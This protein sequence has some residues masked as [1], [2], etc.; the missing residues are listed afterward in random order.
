MKKQKLSERCRALGLQGD[1]TRPLLGVF[2]FSSLGNILM[3]SVP[4]Y[5]L[6][7]YDRVLIS[8]SIETLLVLTALVVF[9][10]SI[11]AIMETVRSRILAKLAARADDDI[12]TTITRLSLYGPHGS[13]ANA[14]T[15]IR[16]CEML[17]RA[18]SPATLG[19][20]FD[21][22]WAPSFIGIVFVMHPYLGYVALI[23]L[24]LLV[25]LAT[26]SE[27]VGQ[28][29]GEDGGPHT[30][31]GKGLIASASQFPSVVRAMG[32][33]PN[34]ITKSRQLSMRG[35]LLSM[36]KDNR[37]DIIINLSRFIRMLAQ[38]GILGIGA[39]LVIG[40]EVT[41]GVMIAASMIMGRGLSPA[42]KLMGSLS[43]MRLGAGAFAR[44]GDFL[45]QLP[46][47]NSQTILAPPIP[48]QLSL[49][50]IHHSYPGTPTPVLSGI[51]LTLS[52]GQ[53]I[54]IVGP[55]SAGKSTL[56]RILVGALAPSRGT[57]EWGGKDMAMIDPMQKKNRIG[58]LPQTIEILDATV[59][60]NISGLSDDSFDDVVTAAKL[61]S[62]HDAILKMPEGYDTMLG[63]KGIPLSGGRAQSIG[64]ARA[65]FRMPE[66]VVMDEPN[67]FLDG[68]AEAGLQ[69]LVT[70]LGKA[71]SAIVIISHKPTLM[72]ILDTLYVLQDGKFRLSGRPEDVHAKILKR[73]G[74][75]IPAQPM[76]NWINGV[77]K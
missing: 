22:I 66:L 35:L 14:P 75:K 36:S 55:N 30:I 17:R 41:A 61:V 9:F 62:I 52:P 74:P 24:V 60:E 26:I 19:T 2:L 34:V 50:D 1:F 4:L 33:G 40:Q 6:Q 71:G 20:V 23:T 37:R 68:P 13:D 25:V 3:L 11:W 47:Q 70:E 54:G 43:A 51:D 46:P 64:L 45:S 48:D 7:I 29:V 58:Y 5:M 39:W 56:A 69:R 31:R 32:M 38:V 57:V 76:M 72:S 59:A 12:S 27:W 15:M 53:A 67:T 44:L 63:T 42:E 8:R 77:P 73:G 28:H 65:V 16:D 21:A 49:K 18:I 10:L